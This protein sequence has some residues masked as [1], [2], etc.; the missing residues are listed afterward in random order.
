MPMRRSGQGYT[1]VEV[2]IAMVLLAVIASLVAAAVQLGVRGFRAGAE[3][4][5]QEEAQRLVLD[6]LSR[7]LEQIVPRREQDATTSTVAFDGRADG[8]KFVAP[9]P[10]QRGVPGL[11]WMEV[12]QAGPGGDLVLS[13]RLLRPGTPKQAADAGLQEKVLLERAPRLTLE[14]YGSRARGEAPAWHG[15][16]SDRERLPYLVR[17]TVGGSHLAQRV[18]LLRARGSDPEAAKRVFAPPNGSA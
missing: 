1:L 6:F 7:S 4:R 8:I 5:A 14:Y 17:I 2:L 11:Y 16:W 13:Y 15:V 3:Q 9:F 12:R 10:R 18:V